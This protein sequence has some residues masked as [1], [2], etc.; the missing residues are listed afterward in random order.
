VALQAIAGRVFSDRGEGA[1]FVALGWVRAALQE[2]LGFDPY[3]GTLN[4]RLE[5]EEARQAWRAFLAR[6]AGL[7]LPPGSPGFCRARLFPARLLAANGSAS[8]A[9]LLPEVEGY[10][11][12]KIEVVA[13]VR[14]KERLGLADGDPV[15]LEFSADPAA[16]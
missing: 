13:P 15:T 11:G 12:E 6:E 9:V 14:L 5:T 7:P 16:G 10:P 2:R 3:P 1:R 4:L 8:G